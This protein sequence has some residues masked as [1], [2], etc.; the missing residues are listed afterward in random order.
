MRVSD[1]QIRVSDIIILAIHKE[2]N[3]SDLGSKP[4]G[5]A[6]YARFFMVL[7]RYVAG[8]IANKRDTTTFT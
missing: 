7:C 6:E 5:L 3:V 1:D 4:C 8:I 2:D